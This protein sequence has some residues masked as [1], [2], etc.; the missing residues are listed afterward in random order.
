MLCLTARSADAQDPRADVDIENLLPLEFGPSCTIDLRA[1]AGNAY[2][3][4]GFP[5]P[6]R[7]LKIKSSGDMN[8]AQKRR[9]HAKVGHRGCRRS[10]D[11]LGRSRRRQVQTDCPP[12]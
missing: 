12:R 4:T 2:H 8:A 5:C 6:A 3:I 11:I 9:T 7:R 1:M 10:P